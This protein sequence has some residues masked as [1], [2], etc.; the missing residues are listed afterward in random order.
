MSRLTMSFSLHTEDDKELID[1]LQALPRSKRSDKIRDLVRNAAAQERS[2]SQPVPH[3][4]ASRGAPATKSTKL[5]PAKPRGLFS[6]P[7]VKP[8]SDS[9]NYTDEENR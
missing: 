2:K 5:E 6:P 4:A 3:T 1:Y 8:D 7:K 9:M